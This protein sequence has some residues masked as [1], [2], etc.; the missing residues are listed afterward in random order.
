MEF[1][2]S[3]TTSRSTPP[4]PSPGVVPGTSVGVVMGTSTGM[5]MGTSVGM[6]MGTSVGVVMGTS[7]RGITPASPAFVAASVRPVLAPASSRARVTMLFQQPGDEQR[8]DRHDPGQTTTL[9]THGSLL[10]GQ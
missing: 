9:A 8:A 4:A 1:D 3:I 10:A 5:V 2:V 6:V 7:T